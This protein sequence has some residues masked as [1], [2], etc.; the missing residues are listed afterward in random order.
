MW[1]LWEVVVT[2]T[3]DCIWS[4]GEVIVTNLVTLCAV[5]VGGHCDI[6]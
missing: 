4:L 6:P 3:S 2:Y 1:S 5:S